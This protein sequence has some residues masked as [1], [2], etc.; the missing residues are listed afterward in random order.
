[1]WNLG[2]NSYD[3]YQKQCITPSATYTVA[4]DNRILAININLAANTHP[5]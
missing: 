5:V 2:I 4:R 1:M 3:T